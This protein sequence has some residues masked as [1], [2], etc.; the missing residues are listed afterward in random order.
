MFIDALKRRS[1]Q[2]AMRDA[3][4]NT[5]LYEEISLEPLTQFTAEEVLWICFPG[6]LDAKWDL[7]NP[8]GVH[9]FFPK[10][11]KVVIVNGPMAIAGTTPAQSIRSM[12]RLTHIVSEL[13]RNHS[14]SALRIFSTSAGTYPGFYFA[15]LFQAQKL[16]AVAPGPRMG[17]GIYTSAFSSP[18]R[19]TCIR[20]GFPTWLEYDDAIAKYNQENNIINLPFDDNL[21]IFGGKQDKVI[22]NYGTI[23]IAELCR[24][25]GK[26][27]RFVNLPLL[28]HYGLGAWLSIQ[29]LL[30]RDPYRLRS[31]DRSSISDVR[32]AS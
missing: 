18:L 30:G 12:E 14:S 15:N 11:G 28:D 13:V 5:A 24:K 27:P 32:S 8:F 23:E 10:Q 29:N 7:H 3:I 9:N 6:F 25:A 4:A 1:S 31:T 22:L 19:D 2:A 21:M 17:Q 26:N 20:N 16:I